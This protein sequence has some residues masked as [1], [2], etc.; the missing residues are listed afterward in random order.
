[1]LKLNPQFM[2]FESKALGRL[3]Y[4]EDG[5]LLNRTNTLIRRDRKELMFLSHVGHREKVAV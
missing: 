2:V 5:S 4:N 3:L 1:M